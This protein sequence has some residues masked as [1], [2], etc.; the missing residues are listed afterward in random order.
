MN[1][2]ELL[3]PDAERQVAQERQ[4]GATPRVGE[5]PGHPPEHGGR[6][7]H[8]GAPAARGRPGSSAR[9]TSRPP[10]TFNDPHPRIGRAAPRRRRSP[11]RRRTPGCVPPRSRCACRALRS[12]R[13]RRR[14]GDSGPAPVARSAAR[15]A[16]AASPPSQPNLHV[17]PAAGPRT[18]CRRAATGRGRRRHTGTT[19]NRSP[20]RMASFTAS[21]SSNS[22]RGD[23][24]IRLIA[25]K[26]DGPNRQQFML[27]SACAPAACPGLRRRASRRSP[28]AIRRRP[29]ASTAYRLTRCV[30][31]VAVARRAPRR[32]KPARPRPGRGRRTASSTAT[33]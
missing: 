33:G 19:A 23:R 18:G 26:I 13:A 30:V 21:A 6:I 16:A 7:A 11:A 14:R 2:L 1:A 32:S 25:S 12:A 20:A 17:R 9:S 28:R 22:P 27:M 8:P 5:V 24:P 10:A 15:T 31:D 4:V 29:P 3:M